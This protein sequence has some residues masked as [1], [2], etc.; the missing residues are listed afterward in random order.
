[1]ATII[2]LKVLE[3]RPLDFK[4]FQISLVASLMA[5]KAANGTKSDSQF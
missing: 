5:V 2:A 1:M 3:Y 4:M